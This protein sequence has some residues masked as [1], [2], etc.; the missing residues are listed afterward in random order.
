ME[1]LKSFK[2]FIAESVE[3]NTKEA[4]LLKQKEE[5]LDKKKEAVAAKDEQAQTQLERSIAILDTEIAKIR[6]AEDEQ[7]SAD[8]R[9]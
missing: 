2:D 1:P 6:K 7:T 8:E 9:V 4:D 3:S 5:L